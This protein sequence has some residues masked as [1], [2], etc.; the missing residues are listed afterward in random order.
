V[1]FGFEKSQEK[2]FAEQKKTLKDARPLFFPFSAKRAN[3]VA[4]D[5]IDIW[6]KK[7]QSSELGLSPPL[8][9]GLDLYMPPVATQDDTAGTV[10]QEQ[11]RSVRVAI[12]IPSRYLMTLK[13]RADRLRHRLE[14]ALK[15]AGR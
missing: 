9:L 12:P 3:A 13:G 7:R 10:T 8:L 11:F 4:G 15:A 14:Q 6:R 1:R 2:R 5:A